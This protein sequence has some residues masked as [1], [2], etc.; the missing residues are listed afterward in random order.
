MSYTHLSA[1]ERGKIEL[2]HGQGWSTTMIG[3]QI[4]RH[5]TTVSREIARNGVKSGYKAEVAHKRYAQR[6]EGCRPR[7]RLDHVA[8]RKFVADKIAEEEWT[9]ELVAGRLRS[10]YPDDPRMRVCPETIYQSIY[11]N[12]H[13]LDYLVVFLPQARPKRRKRGQGKSRRGPSIPNRVSIHERPQTIEQR[14]EI[15]HWE[16]DLV[17]GKNQDGFILTLVERCSRQTVAVLVETKHASPIA[18]AVIEALQDHPISWVKSITFDNGTEFADHKS[19]TEHLHAAVYFAD[20]YAAYQRGSNEQ[21]NGLIRRYLPKGTSFKDL[22]Q[23]KLDR[24]IQT[25]NNRPRK[26]LAYQTP[27]EVFLK[28]RQEHRRAL[29]A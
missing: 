24:I 25:I 19:I 27:N 4:G 10:E 26:C 20:P 9:P 23:Q 17:V 2:L 14:E 1:V 29:S 18:Q 5:R 16:G 13:K 8:L 12:L 3:Q 22:D 7:Y 28:Q 11:A 21:V 6:R 15:G